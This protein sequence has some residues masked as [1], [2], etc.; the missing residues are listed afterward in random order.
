[1]T[2]SKLAELEK[3]IYGENYSYEQLLDDI[4]GLSISK[5][6]KLNFIAHCLTQIRS[7]VQIKQAID[8]QQGD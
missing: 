5:E 2:E 4:E 6:G 7:V 3:T 8:E 1:L